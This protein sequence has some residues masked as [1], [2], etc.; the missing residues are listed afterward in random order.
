MN[1]P[2]ICDYGSG[3]SKVGFAGTEAP[4]A[5]F[6]T[7][8]GKLRHE[9]LLVGMEEED[10]FIGN[11]V[12]K[13][14]GKLN[15]LYPISRAAITNWDDMEK[16]LHVAPEQHP[17]LMAEPPLNST[18]SKERLSQ[19]QQVRQLPPEGSAHRRAQILFET[20]SV[21]ALYLANQGVLSL[22]ASGHTAADRECARD[23]KEKNCFVALDFEKEKAEANSPSYLQKCQL[24]DGQEI[25][26][27]RERFFCP[28]ALFQPNLIERNNLGIHI[29][30]FECISSCNPALWKILFGHIILSGGTGTCSGLRSRLQK[31]ASA[32]VSPKINVKAG[33]LLRCG[34]C[35][36]LERSLRHWSV[37]LVQPAAVVGSCSGLVRAWKQQRL[38]AW[39]SSSA[40][41]AG[42]PLSSPWV[43]CVGAA[44][45]THTVHSLALE[46]SVSRRQWIRCGDGETQAEGRRE[47][48]PGERSSEQKHAPPLPLWSSELQCREGLRDIGHVLPMTQL[49][50]SA[51]F[52]A[53]A[54]PVTLCSSL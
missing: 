36:S 44:D 48:R 19:Q 30:A 7:T 32:L 2:L 27:G 35:P 42:H 41:V 9:K 25:D 33:N 12:P 31:E 28:E 50:Q 24:P 14:R 45:D 15:L 11:E 4:L 17:L 5:V 18:S 39:S 23:L 22:Y 10:W 16:V 53:L 46:T 38:S 47:R 43:A 29:K 51:D 34:S 21:P 49:V 54:D 6:P 26:L 13:N 1:V 8:L 37:H 52:R 20:F 3:F 40:E